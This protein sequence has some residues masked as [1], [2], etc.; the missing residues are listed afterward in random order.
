MRYRLSLSFS[1]VIL[2]LALLLAVIPWAPAVAQSTISSILHVGTVSNAIPV[3][4]GSATSTDPHYG[5]FKMI[6]A[7]APFTLEASV[8]KAISFSGTTKT[9]LAG[10]KQALVTWDITVAERDSA[11][12]TYDLYVTSG[13]GVSS[14]DVAHFPQIATTGAKRYTAAIEA[15]LQPQE[16]TTATPGVSAV[17]SGTLKTDTAG[18]GEGIKTLAAG[19]VR[20]GALG[21][22]LGYELVIAGTIATGITYSVTVTPRW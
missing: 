2:A 3:G 13:D 20:H 17:M 6:G 5:V 4:Y 16:I 15:G 18:S 7:G 11:N 9:G 8:T 12:E 21:D 1:A 14:W 10:F 22:R 19:K